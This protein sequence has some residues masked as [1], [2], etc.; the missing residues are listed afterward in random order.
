MLCWFTKIRYIEKCFFVVR[1]VIEVKIEL[2]LNQSC[3]QFTSI[4]VENVQLFNFDF[5]VNF[6]MFVIVFD[7]RVHVYSCTVVDNKDVALSYNKHFKEYSKCYC[8]VSSRNELSQK[9][10]Q[11]KYLKKFLKTMLQSSKD[12]CYINNLFGVDCRYN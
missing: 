6:D 7:I 2:D 5:D 12:R 11:L 9:I 10:Y 4:F 1:D 3:F 8:Y